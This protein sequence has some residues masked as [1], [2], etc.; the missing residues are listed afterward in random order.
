M[1]SDEDYYYQGEHD[2]FEAFNIQEEREE[3]PGVNKFE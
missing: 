1:S 3:L 2:D